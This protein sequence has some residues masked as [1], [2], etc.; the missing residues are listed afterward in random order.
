MAWFKC[1]GPIEGGGMTLP[2]NYLRCSK[3][4]YT[5][6]QNKDPNTLY[7]ID[8]IKNIRS[9][10][11]SRIIDGIREIYLGTQMIY[12]IK[13]DGYDWCIENLEFPDALGTDSETG[14]SYTVSDYEIN[15]DIDLTS[16]E[17]I[18]KNFQIE[19][20]ATLS[21]TASLSGD[22]VIFGGTMS[23]S[24][25][26]ECYL[27]TSGHLY[28]Y[29]NGI[30]DSKFI[31]DANDHDIKIVRDGS[32]IEF[33]KDG[34]L[35]TT[36]STYAPDSNYSGFPIG[37]ARYNNNSSATFHGTIHYLKFKWLPTT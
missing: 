22:Q 2:T 13:K 26:F 4:H 11:N 18:N 33:Y 30:S 5:N 31:D 16:S 3:E 24:G 15:M 28:F 21:Q 37:I 7:F 35:I 25:I 8:T 20:K 9:S 29:A 27:N 14:K 12:P 19:F 34:T 23:R 1:V 6:L 10:W 36:V 32:N 17:N